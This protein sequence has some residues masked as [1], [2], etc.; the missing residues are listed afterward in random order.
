M[1]RSIF[2][3]S[4]SVDLHDLNS[5]QVPDNRLATASSSGASA[6]ERSAQEERHAIS[7]YLAS[8]FHEYRKQETTETDRA[9]NRQIEDLI[10]G[11]TDQLIAKG[12]T[13]STIQYTMSKAKFFDR[14]ATTASS[15]LGGSPFSVAIAMQF[16]MGTSDKYLNVNPLGAAV[17]NGLFAGSMAGAFDAVGTEVF[18]SA[19]EDIHFLKAPIGKL[20]ASLADSVNDRQYGMAAETAV[21]SLS[22]QTFTLRNG[23]R[24]AAR[25]SM[26]NIPEQ[27]R[28]V[29]V[30]LST[31]GGILAAVLRGHGMQSLEEHRG[32]WG[33]AMLFGRRDE[34]DTPIED[35]CSWVQIYDALKDASLSSATLHAVERLGRTVRDVATQRTELLKAAWT[36]ESTISTFGALGGGFALSEGVQHTLKDQGFADN[37]GQMEAARLGLPAL[38]FAAFGAS[39]AA[40]EMLGLLK[41]IVTADNFSAPKR[42]I[43]ITTSA[44]GSATSYLGDLA[45]TGGGARGETALSVGNAVASTARQ[46]IPQSLTSIGHSINTAV[47]IGRNALRG[48]SPV[49]P[50]LEQRISDIQQRETARN[51]RP[52]SP[53]E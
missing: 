47:G 24:E 53:H 22:W 23:I 32:D 3:T 37:S 51:Q 35:E 31:L 15:A 34:G 33:P 30:S 25:Q 40:A 52:E 45:R 29:D 43:N 20:H 1:I 16:F 19:R 11:R 9:H 48:T 50:D 39:G 14:L 38:A 10:H 44:V 7:D 2:T 46:A 12:E 26:S 28:K 27:A 6:V 5:T 41:N 18:K 4:H 13:L 17:L 21:Q 36:S 49:I 42:L 8:V